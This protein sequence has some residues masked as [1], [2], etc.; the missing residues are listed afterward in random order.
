MKKYEDYIPK[1]DAK[2]M[3]WTELWIR[4][5]QQ[6]TARAMPHVQSAEKTRH[7]ELARKTINS[8][9]EVYKGKKHLAALVSEKEMLKKEFIAEARAY[10]NMAKA[11]QQLTDEEFLESGLTCSNQ[12][13]DFS[14]L[15]PK[16]KTAVYPGHVEIFFNKHNI[17]SVAIYCRL[18][19]DKGEWRL[20]AKTSKSPFVDKTPLQV[21]NR[22][23][24]REYSA[25]FTNVDE[26]LGQ[27]SAVCMLTFG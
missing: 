14:E 8:M 23:E 16:I 1:A 10:I 20:V 27:R 9:E 18:P 26:L 17:L 19:E 5:F 13:L 22:P 15:R 25:I 7:L 3:V 24:K 6:L 12:T 11:C 4:G 21:A 2:F